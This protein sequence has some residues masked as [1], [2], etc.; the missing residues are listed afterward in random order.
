MG[1]AYERGHVLT[2]HKGKKVGNSIADK[3]ECIW[4]PITFRLYG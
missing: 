3:L 4:V 1:Q 2:S